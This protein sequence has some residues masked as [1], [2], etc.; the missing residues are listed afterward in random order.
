MIVP[1]AYCST[2]MQSTHES[3]VFQTQEAI[4]HEVLSFR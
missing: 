1:S 4:R 2:F 3:V